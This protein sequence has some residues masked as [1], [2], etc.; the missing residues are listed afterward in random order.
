MS[1]ISLSDMSRIKGSF[2]GKQTTSWYSFIQIVL[3]KLSLFMFQAGA[4]KLM[5]TEQVTGNVH[6]L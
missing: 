3:V 4:V 5:A 2:W 1:L 6:C